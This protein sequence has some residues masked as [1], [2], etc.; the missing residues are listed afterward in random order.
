MSRAPRRPAW[1]R[2]WALAVA[3]ALVVAMACSDFSAPDDPASGLPDVA[4]T[5]PTLSADVQPILTKRCS[6]GGC[7]SL[8]SRRAGLVLTADSSYAMLVNRISTERPDLRRV[9]PGNPDSSWLYLR[10][11]P[12][13]SL[14][15]SF[16]RMPLAS[17]P[18]TPNQ[19]A[20]IANWIA[21]GAPR[22]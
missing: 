8:V 12:D 13:Q 17:H 4:V 5:A 2:G 21:R 20:T 19:I 16:P 11:Q 9:L 1:A 10:V 7:H 15:G 6:I 22:D 14:R 3:G 18:L